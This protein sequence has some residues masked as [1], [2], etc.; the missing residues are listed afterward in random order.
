MDLDHIAIAI[1]DV[2]VPL[3]ALVGELGA[4]VQHGGPSPGF[5]AMQVQLGEPDGMV[6]ELIEPYLTEQ[7]DF[8]RRFLDRHGEGPHHITFKTDDIRGDL[9]RVRAAG[10]EPVNVDLSMPW[11]QEAF[12]MP[13]DAG[14]T[15]VQIAQSAYDESQMTQVRDE[16]RS[17]GDPW[18][19][20]QWWHDP[21]PRAEDR[22]VLRRVVMRTPSVPTAVG[23]FS[24]LLGGTT[25]ER[26]DG[27]VELVWPGGGRIRFEESAD[28]PGVDRLECDWSGQPTEWAIGGARFVLGPQA[29]SRA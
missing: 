18:G 5:R 22:A 23:L 4:L 11:W 9:E 19:S 8:L 26:G 27:F 28:R 17:E 2:N 20:F 7:N 29:R 21:P 10:I 14:G 12:L 3:A 13:R 1:P 24:G 6:V 15:V 16:M 25:D